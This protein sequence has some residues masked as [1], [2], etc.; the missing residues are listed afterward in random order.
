MQVPD[1]LDVL[2]GENVRIELDGSTADLTVGGSGAPG[3][4]VLK[5]SAGNEIIRITSG[6]LYIKDRESDVMFRVGPVE[7]VIDLGP[8]PVTR[9]LGYEL[10]L[11][12]NEAQRR[13][14]IGSDTG[15][16]LLGGNGVGGEILL[17]PASGESE[18]PSTAT[19]H[20]DGRSANLRMGGNGADG[21][22]LLFRS[23]GDPA[24]DATSTIS[25]DAGAAN[26]RMGGNGAGGDL[27]LFRA[28]GDPT[29]D[30]TS[31]IHLNASGA[32]VRVGG[33]GAGGNLLLFRDDSDRTI[34]G[35]ASI[36]LD[37][38]RG[39][40][41]LGGNGA[42]GDILLFPATGDPSDGSTATIHL[43][44]DTGDIRLSGAD[45]AEA[46]GV[47]DGWGVTPGMVLV[48]GQEDR[49]QPCEEAYDRRVVGV[50]SGA[51]DL[52]PAILLNNTGANSD[53][54]PVALVGKTFCLVDA[55]YGQ[56]HIGDLL[57][58][59]STPGHAMRA[60]DPARAFGAVIGKALREL[61]EGRG[62]IPILVSLQ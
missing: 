38:Q 52:R 34:D 8:P 47:R 15:D 51:G 39:N 25:L 35:S 16:M 55:R 46:F 6:G 10:V 4:L 37:G 36:S 57:T 28:D 56:I 9:R 48:A 12:G 27:L 3:D 41:R 62:L 24:D 5:D 29:N 17:F 13:C 20:L 26:L 50:V 22:I 31:T 14:R 59:S 45:C 7:E 1:R 58:T 49:L 32:N 54:V 60:S 42:D 2:D 30:A 18:E 53:R 44:A 61:Q 21:D 33:N 11:N 23:G 43:D 40:V 19:M